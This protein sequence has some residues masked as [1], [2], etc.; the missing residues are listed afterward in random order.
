MAGAWLSKEECVI[1]C[2]RMELVYDSDVGPLGKDATP[3]QTLALVE[4][5]LKHC[6]DVTM[7]GSSIRRVIMRILLSKKLNR[8]PKKA[9]TEKAQITMALNLN[10]NNVESIL[11]KHSI[12]NSLV[13]LSRYTD[14]VNSEI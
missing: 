10:Y 11:R 5:E 3:L 1:E 9:E 8:S 6:L 13:F 2:A 14:L 12:I 7:K 4:E